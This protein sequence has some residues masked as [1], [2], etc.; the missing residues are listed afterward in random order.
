MAIRERLQQPIATI[1]SYN[2]CDK[3]DT[4]QSKGLWRLFINED[5]LVCEIL[6]TCS[7]LEVLCL[8]EIKV[9]QLAKQQ[10]S[11]LKRSFT[12]TFDSKAYLFLNEMHRYFNYI[13]DK[14]D[15]SLPV[16][17]RTLGVDMLFPHALL[18]IDNPNKL[19]TVEMNQSSPMTG[20]FDQLAN[21]NHILTISNTL[22]DK[23]DEEPF[24]KYIAHQL[25]LLYRAVDHL[26]SRKKQYKQIILERFEE[27][28]QACQNVNQDSSSTLTPEMKSW[29]VDLT[30]SITDTIRT[31]PHDITDKMQP[32]I[33]FYLKYNNY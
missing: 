8:A 11:I 17:L 9:M 24:H 30:T 25:A 28:K 20:Y 23:I 5:E 14:E 26:G 4:Y 2:P 31:L 29:I 1:M 33:N 15:I 10:N 12:T 32:F 22:R 13:S 19:L 7:R 21:L 16:Y 18:F 3:V 6:A 27:I